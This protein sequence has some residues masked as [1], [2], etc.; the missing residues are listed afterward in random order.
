MTRKIETQTITINKGIIPNPL[1]EITTVK[2]FPKTSKEATHQ[3]IK[4]KLIKYEQLKKQIQ[5]PW[6][7]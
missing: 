4:G 5:T 7:R 1:I 6:Y 2:P 3:K